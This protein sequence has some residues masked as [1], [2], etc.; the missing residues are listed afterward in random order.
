MNP[1]A[2][3]TLPFVAPS[4]TKKP[5]RRRPAFLLR[6]QRELARTM[7]LEL[8]ANARGLN[9]SEHPNLCVRGKLGWGSV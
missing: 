4:H 3:G 9:G 2:G 1:P 7:Q 6:P 8:G 5:Y